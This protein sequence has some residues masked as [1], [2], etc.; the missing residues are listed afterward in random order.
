MAAIAALTICNCGNAVSQTSD[1]QLTLKPECIGPLQKAMSEVAAG[2]LTEAAE[3]LSAALRTAGSSAGNPCAGL[4]L[5]N[6]ATIASISG[7]FGDAERL[8]ARSIAA[9]EKLYPADDR[10]LWRPLMLLA[11]ARLEQGNKSGARA[12][13]KRLR[14][15]RPEQPEDRAL[16]H[17]TVASLLQHLGEHREAEFEYLAALKGWQDS[18]RGETV[19][20]AAVRVS[21]ATLLIEDRRLEEARHL[22]DR[23]AAALSQSK[24]TA[25]MDR[26][27]LLMVRGA[28]HA[29]LRRWPDAEID[30]REALVIADGQPA[31]DAGYI[32]KLLISFTEALNKNHHRQEGRRM[33]I[34]SAALRFA[35]PSLDA[36][37]DISD[38]GARPR[39]RKK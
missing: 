4:I 5:H 7:R 14:E 21:F 37:V 22:L 26:S 27:K 34:R 20:A 1:V 28:L 19:D 25:P 38:L 8:A 15:I 33:E 6:L 9:L 30:F 3:E 12:D 24:E 36:I 17:G 31:V 11:G 13:L 18:G 29:R 35:S 39:S 32:L 10:A 2:Q 23:A 16:I